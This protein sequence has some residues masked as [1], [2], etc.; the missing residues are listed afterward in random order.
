MKTKLSQTERLF[1]L[2]FLCSLLF[3]VPVLA[4]LQATVTPGH[5]FGASERPTTSTLNRLGQPTITITG[6]VGGTNANISAAS[7]NGTMLVNGLPGSNLTY[8]GSSPRSIV[9][10]NS[11]VGSNQVD[12]AIAGFGLTG[13]GGAYFKVNIDSNSI[14]S[15]ADGDGIQ[16]TNLQPW[17]IT[18]TTNTI[19]GATPYGTNA[20]IGLPAGWYIST[21]LTLSAAGG[22]TSGET[23]VGLPSDVAHSLGLKP[24]IVNWVFICKTSDAG[25]AV[26]DELPMSQVEDITA[27]QPFNYGANSTN[28]FY[29]PYSG[30]AGL[31]LRL[32]NKSSGALDTF[33]LA[34]WKAKCYARP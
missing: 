3:T 8:D 17:R 28:V 13:G 27:S 32:Y 7:I 29:R 20:A 33:T 5:V 16:V 10:K 12:A 31:T 26:G 23:D 21:N 22:F 2:C 24:G 18:W 6:T 14:V 34:R 1:L 15:T 25:Y 11:G 4:D 9:I 19:L 30:V